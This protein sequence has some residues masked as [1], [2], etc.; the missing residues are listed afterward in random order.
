MDFYLGYIFAANNLFAL[1]ITVFIKLLI[2]VYVYNDAKSHDLNRTLWIVLIIILPS[3]VTL[4]AYLI[5][6][7]NNEYTSCPN[8]Q[9]KV[10]KKASICP[11]CNQILTHTCPR[12]N[13]IIKEEWDSCPYC[14]EVLRRNK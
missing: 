6:R 9:F 10:K 7:Q 8:C 1:I 5:F 14:T 2:A 4:I 13:K 11:N 3:Y 12:C